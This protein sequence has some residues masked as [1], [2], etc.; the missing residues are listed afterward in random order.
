MN[1]SQFI[2]VQCA[3][4]ISLFSL[5][6]HAAVIDRGNGLIYDNDLDIIWLADANYSYTSGYHVDGFMTYQE[7]QIWVNQLVFGGYDDWRLTQ[8][9]PAATGPYCN[10]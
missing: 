1:N 2:G 3:T 5:T 10:A 6:S 7:S 8:R 4:L 9:L